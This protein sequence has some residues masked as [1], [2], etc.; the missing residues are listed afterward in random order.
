MLECFILETFSI[1]TG[2]VVIMQKALFVKET[3]RPVVLNTRDVPEPKKGQ[4][5]IKVTSTMSELPSV[6]VAQNSF[7]DLGATFFWGHLKLIEVFQSS[8]MVLMAET[9]A[10]SSATSCPTFWAQMWRALFRNLDQT[11]RHSASVIVFLV[12]LT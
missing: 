8:P 1:K 7:E 12:K 2:L 4:V 11:F 6:L 3:G 5:L 9:L 10:S